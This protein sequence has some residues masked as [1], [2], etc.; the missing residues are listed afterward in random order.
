MTEARTVTNKVLVVVVTIA[1]LFMTWNSLHDGQSRSAFGTWRLLC[2][3]TSDVRLDT[4]FEGSA[5]VQH[6]VV[7]W[8]RK[9]EE[10][11][12]IET[13]SCSIKSLDDEQSK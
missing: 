13:G 11:E 1:V 7:R 10:R 4:T 2:F 8:S 6:G 9:G 12:W 3:E 5:R